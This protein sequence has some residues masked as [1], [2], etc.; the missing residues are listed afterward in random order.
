MNFETIF[1][2]LDSTLYPESNGLW[3]A[4]RTRIDQYMYERMGFSWDEI[5]RIRSHFLSNHGTTLKGLQI[6]YKVDAAD[7][8]HYVHDL[9]LHNYL[10]PDPILRELLLSIPGRRWVFTNSD[11]SHAN[12]VMDIL[13]IQDCF[14]GLIDILTMDP[15]CKPEEEAYKFALKHVGTN[16][17]TSC[18]ILDDS[19]N[20]LVPAKSLGIFTVLV[21]ENGS[22]P[23]VDRSLENIHDLRIQ[24]PEFWP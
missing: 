20:N 22:H 18:A 7:Y 10:S 15:L 9:P 2:D 19:I 5:P 17:P 8:L 24:V 11:A 14:E 12:R 6:H 16:E 3:A 13:G 1:F 21:G 4:I 23:C